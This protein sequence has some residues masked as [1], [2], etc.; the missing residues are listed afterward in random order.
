P[1]AAMG[2]LAL[3]Q[4]KI[5][6]AESILTQSLPTGATVAGG[7]VDPGGAPLSAPLIFPL[8][9]R[10]FPMYIMNEIASIQPMDRPEGKIFYRDQLRT[11]DPAPGQTQRIDLNTSSNPFNSSYA[12]NNVEGSAAS[13]I[14]LSLQSVTVTAQTKKLAAAWSIEE[15]QD[16]RAYHGLDAAQELMNGTARE[17]AIE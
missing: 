16:L 15:M 14:K 17:M 1:Q 11:E 3:E 10:V 8:I 2:L 13:I 5:A 4:G 12:D 9:R 7:N 6:K